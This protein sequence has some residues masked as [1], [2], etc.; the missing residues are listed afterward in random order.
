MESTITSPLRKVLSKERRPLIVLSFVVLVGSMLAGSFTPP[1]ATLLQALDQLSQEVQ[2]GGYTAIFINNAIIAMT[3]F[4][5]L[6]GLGSAFSASF[7]TGAAMSALAQQAGVNAQFLFLTTMIMPHTV[8]EFAAYSLALAENLVI[9]Q[10]LL[11]RKGINAEMGPL[12][13]T[14]LL[15]LG[16]LIVG[17][18]VEILTTELITGS[19]V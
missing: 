13:Y 2:S 12:I 8:I 19:L 3:F 11:L 9:M 16:L 14:I 5:P 6:L 18:V 10:K 1:D 4:V 7:T 15:V 17:A